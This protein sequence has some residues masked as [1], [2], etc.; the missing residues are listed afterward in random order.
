MNFRSLMTG[1]ALLGLS[2]IA[3]EAKTICTVIANADT[4]DFIVKEGR[5]EERFTPASTFKVPLAVMGYDSGFLTDAHN[6]TLPFRNGDPD[7]G[8]ENWKQPTDATRWLKYSVVWFSQRITAKLGEEKLTE[9]ARQ[10]HYGNADFSG[11]PGKNNGL[12]RAWIIS[13][14][15][16]SPIEQITFLRRLINHELPV[17]NAAVDKTLAIVE[18]RMLPSGWAVQGKT[19]MAYPRNADYSFDTSHPFGWYVG[20][21][22]K[23]GQRIVFARLIQDDKKMEGSASAR[24]RDSLFEELPSLIP[25]E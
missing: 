5:C 18:G 20:W 21:G 19:G 1:L 14:L 22:E 15:K 12:E 10:F 17:S 8:G 4:G 25:A 6:P 24:A 3:A 11:D 2:A 9:Y 16:V 7:W 23:G 13:S